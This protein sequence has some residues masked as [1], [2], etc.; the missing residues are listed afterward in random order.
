MVVKHLHAGEK[1]DHEGRT[2]NKK[3]VKT[4]ERKTYNLTG[5]EKARKMDRK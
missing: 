3:R 5:S 1:K 2:G 4:W